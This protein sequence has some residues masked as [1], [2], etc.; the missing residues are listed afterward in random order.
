MSGASA[1]DF[2]KVGVFMGFVDD[3][4]DFDPNT[5]NASPGKLNGNQLN[6]IAYQ[7]ERTWNPK[8]WF[9]KGNVKNWIYRVGST[10][11]VIYKPSPNTPGWALMGISRSRM[12]YHPNA[13]S[14]ELYAKIFIDKNSTDP[15][16]IKYLQPAGLSTISQWMDLNNFEFA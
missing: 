10:R 11:L 14:M 7:R 16:V 6:L 3:Y 2:S 5:K 4:R 8:T 15:D 9:G 12:D 13:I 1:I